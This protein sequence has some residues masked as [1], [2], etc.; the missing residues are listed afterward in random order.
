MIRHLLIGVDA[1]R[2][3]NLI[4]IGILL[5]LLFIRCVLGNSI[6]GRNLKIKVRKVYCLLTSI[7]NLLQST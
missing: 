7:E 4:L 1:S 6:C 3:R 5:L 2:R